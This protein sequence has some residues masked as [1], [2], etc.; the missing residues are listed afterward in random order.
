MRE[1][2]PSYTI[3]EQHLQTYIHTLCKSKVWSLGVSL[4]ITV[5][6]LSKKIVKKLTFYFHTSSLYLKRLYKGLHGLRRTV[7]PLRYHKEV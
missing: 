4:T 2:T 6:G 5:S 1:P 3:F 7:E